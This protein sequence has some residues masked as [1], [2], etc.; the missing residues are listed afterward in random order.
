MKVL[1]IFGTRPEI[2]RLS[3]IIPLLD[4]HC[5]HV[6]IHTGQNYDEALSDVFFRELGVRAPDFHL[7][8]K[9]AGFEEQVGQILARAGEVLRRERPDRVLILG[10]TNSG[11][12]AIVACR[13]GIPV[14]HI[15]AGNRC[16]DDRVPEEVNRRII[17]TCSTVLMPYTNRSKD[18]LL[19]EGVPRERIHVVGNPI[20]EVLTAYA[21]RI[22]ASEVLTRLKLTRGQY[23]AVTLH[24]TENVDRP[25]RLRAL[26]EGF[27]AVREEYGQPVVV[28]LHPRTEDRLTA[29]GIDPKSF[30]LA[31]T[32]PLGLFDWVSLEKHARCVLTDSGTLQD[33]CSIFH[34]PMVTVR[35]V[36]ER[37][38]TQ[39]R[40]SNVLAGADKDALLRSVGLA[41]AAPTDWTVPPEYLEPHVSATVAKI[42]LGHLPF[43]RTRT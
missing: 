29:A 3:R 26:L 28:S 36:T 7:G 41:L 32:R 22:E 17:D 27:Q 9:A 13:L 8:V 38:E 42:V 37:A 14:F 15:E 5:K 18:N 16:Y 39:E 1:T 19:E 12:A 11:L 2:I 33:E 40:G 30:D 21:D 6:L 31:F 23:F 25:E 34:V 35:D 43:G 10:D 24:R 20:F 4:A